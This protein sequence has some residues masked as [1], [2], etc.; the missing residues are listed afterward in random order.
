MSK[1]E[2]YHHSSV[3]SFAGHQIDVLSHKEEQGKH[4]AEVR[5][6]EYHAV[7]HTTE[8]HPTKE[9]ALV[10]AKKWVHSSS[11]QAYRSR[12][13]LKIFKNENHLDHEQMK[14]H[15][16]DTRSFSNA[17]NDYLEDTLGHKGHWEKKNV[18]LHS[19]KRQSGMEN[20]KDMPPSGTHGPIIVHPK[21]H[22]IDGNHRHAQAQR[23]GKTHIEAWIP[24]KKSELFKSEE[25]S[26]KT[27][28]S[29][30]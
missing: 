11:P 29:K 26:I 5:H 3:H 18:P 2:D 9:R 15:L 7:I 25:D 6:P 10:E 14:E 27:F 19:V 17:D 23:E 1:S 24:V 30:K 20:H 22:I 13:E 8:V 28:F 4:I 21:G 12:R 16:K